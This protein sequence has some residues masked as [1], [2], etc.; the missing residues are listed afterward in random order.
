MTDQ[1][2]LQI[3]QKGVAAWN[4]W[5]KENPNIAPKLREADL[6]DSDYSNV[7]FSYAELSDANLTLSLLRGA[8]LSNAI[9]INTSIAE[10]Y[11]ENANLSGS[12]MHYTNFS[13][14][15]LS[16]VN[17]SGASLFQVMFINADLSDVNFT[18]ADIAGVIFTNND[19][20]SAMGLE[21]VIHSGPSS[22]GID[23]IY[24]SK[25]NI[26]E[27][28]LREAGVPDDL[29]TY[30]PSLLGRGIEFYSCF[31]SYSH[32]DEGFAKRLHLRL[33][34]AHIRVWF[35]PEDI[36]GGQKLHEQIDRAIQ[37]YDRLLIVLSESSLRSEW[38][39]TEIRKARK[40]EVKEKRR[41]LFP[42][43]L[44]DYET[45]REWE[46]FDVD[47]G[48]DLAAEVREYYIPDFSNWKD[49]DSFELAFEKLLRDLK[50]T[51]P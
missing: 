31:I 5:R 47:T 49:Q 15:S 39:M 25:G 16:G 41:K 4:Q 20:S 46:C 9:L 14:S 8:N 3:L 19:L 10:A 22:I 35:A 1:G 29:I 32:Q 23:T 37:I 18:S 13:D 33:R 38:V 42:I 51:A 44:T 36:R 2:H 12:E 30:F 21:T 24:R 26:P 34:D 45:L 28:F 40:A 7:D 48:K 50:A 27:S 43:R 11:L 6:R 17:L